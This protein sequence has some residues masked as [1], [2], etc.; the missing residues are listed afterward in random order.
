M[1]IS[2]KIGE[3][4]V[5]RIVEYGSIFMRHRWIDKWRRRSK[6]QALDKLDCGHGIST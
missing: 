2:T 1:G 4:L 6:E 3:L 5:K